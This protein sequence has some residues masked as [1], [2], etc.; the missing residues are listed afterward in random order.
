MKIRAFMFFLAS[1][2]SGCFGG[3]PFQPPPPEFENWSKTGVTDLDVK[4]AMLECG[5]PSPYQAAQWRIGQAVT[6]EE[7]ALMYVC[8]KSYGFVFAGGVT[9]FVSTLRI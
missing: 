4:K 1:C 6:Q 8:M 2:I 7:F 5:Y 9:T 3:E